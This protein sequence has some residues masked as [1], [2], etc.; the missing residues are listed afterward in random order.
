MRRSRYS[1]IGVTLLEIMLVLAIASMVI[2]MSVRYYESATASAQV[3]TVLQQV[4]SIT[5]AADGLAQGSNS[6]LTANIV[7]STLSPI[8]PRNGLTLPWGRTINVTTPS[9]SS[10]VIVL[11]EVPSNQCPLIV[12]KLTVN[13]HFSVTPT[14]NVGALTTLS[15]T[16]TATN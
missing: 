15:I 1:I 16:Y 7:S 8:L 14:C 12:S 6:Y 9:N 5:A 3:N 13:T 10:Y 4:Q 2:V 11:N